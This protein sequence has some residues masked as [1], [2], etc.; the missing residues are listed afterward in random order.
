MSASKSDKNITLTAAEKYGLKFYS[1][2]ISQLCTLAL[3]LTTRSIPL[4]LGFVSFYNVIGNFLPI[5]VDIERE[6]HINKL[7]NNNKYLLGPL[8]ASC[9]STPIILYVLWRNYDQLV[10][11]SVL[12]LI[13]TLF[14]FGFAISGSIDASHE[15]LHRTESFCKFF[16]YLNLFFLQFTIYPTEHLYLHH[17]KVGTK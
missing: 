17:K 14:V 5:K 10:G 8:I 9:L 3:L 12:E 2:F 15:L 13:P 16:S 7:Q 11:D 4:A 1:F 6:K